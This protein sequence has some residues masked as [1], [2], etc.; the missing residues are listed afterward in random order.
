MQTAFIG[1]VVL[2]EPLLARTHKLF[3]RAAI[4]VVVIPAAAN[5]LETHPA[6][7]EVVVYDK[8][9][10]HRGWRG[11]WALQRRLK[12][13]QYD[14]A[15][16]PHRSLRSALLV[17]LAGIP[18]RIGFSTSAGK[19]LFTHRVPYQQVHEV[20]RNLSLLAQFGDPAAYQPPA[21]YPT[22]AD[23]QLAT[24]LLPAGD[25]PVVALAPGSVWATK[26]WPIERF[27]EL[28]QHL[29]R[30]TPCRLVLLGGAGDAA[31]CDSLAEELGDRR[32]VNLAGKLTLRQS[33]ALL[34]R[35]NVLVTNDSAPTHL[36]VAAGCRVVTIFGA[37]VPRFGFYPNGAPHRVVETERNLAC[38]PCGI[39]GGHRCP[40]GTFECMLSISSE[41]IF[42][43]VVEMLHGQEAR[44][45]S[46]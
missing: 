9:N 13:Q 12:N 31:L 39:H 21:I 26:R 24:A 2:V 3:P 34:A 28:G 8:R 15:L 23:R 35:C 46:K 29:L 10:R 6:V 1:D 41:R 22:T 19:A 36:G 33:V 40:V 25:A 14:L 30:Q 4:D 32:C 16:V 45:A 20:E 5:L 42:R 43:T 17:W 11:F 7:R 27:A 38:R 44:P 18:K 37:T